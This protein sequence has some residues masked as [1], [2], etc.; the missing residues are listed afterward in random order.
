MVAKVLV[1]VN[2]DGA[3]DS[4]NMM[5]LFLGFL[6][7]FLWKP[8][9]IM[10][11]NVSIECH[12]STAMK[13]SKQENKKTQ[14][15]Y[16]SSLFFVVVF[17]RCLFFSRLALRYTNMSKDTLLSGSRQDEMFKILRSGKRKKKAQARDLATQRRRSTQGNIILL[18]YGGFHP[19]I[20]HPFWVPPFMETSK[21]RYVSFDLFIKQ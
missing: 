9:T 15:K 13:A 14:E 17:C 21:Y 11:V 4:W 12:L 3:W 10:R 6:L 8:A 7:G 5:G 18:S 16:N 19:F 20:N 2:A 1:E